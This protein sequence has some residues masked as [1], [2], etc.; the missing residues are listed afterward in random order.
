MCV[1]LYN[2]KSRMIYTSG[3]V[4]MME[5]G[6]KSGFARYFLIIAFPCVRSEH[7]NHVRTLLFANIGKDWT[8]KIDIVDKQTVR[9]YDFDPLYAECFF[10]QRTN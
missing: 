9:E 2:C 4:A 3:V 6:P 7:S 8:S 10:F 1:K 5:I